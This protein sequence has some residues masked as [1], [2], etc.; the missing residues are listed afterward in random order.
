MHYH[1]ES[2]ICLPERSAR[3][4]LLRNLVTSSGAMLGS[5]AEGS[6]AADA[7]SIS[8]SEIERRNTERYARASIN[9]SSRDSQIL[10]ETDVP[11]L[12]SAGRRE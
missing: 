6:F 8:N 1:S 10:S 12:R 9:E 5:S 4:I 2:K 7:K 3:N 11:R